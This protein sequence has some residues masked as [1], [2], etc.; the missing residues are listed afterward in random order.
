M[1]RSGVNLPLFGGMLVSLIIHIVFLPLVVFLLTGGGIAVLPTRPRVD[2][3]MIELEYPKLGREDRSVTT[4]A[5]I[6]YEDYRKLVAPLSFTEQPAV[7]DRQDPQPGSPI[8]IDPVQ[9]VENEPA[10][11]ESAASSKQ[12]DRP[13][14]SDWHRPWHLP[15]DLPGPAVILPPERQVTS[16]G[17]ASPSGEKPVDRPTSAPRDE[18][19]ADPVQMTDH[20]LAWRPGGVLVGEGIEVV[21]ARPEFGIITRL[22]AIPE[23]TE[24]ELVFDSD[25]M[26]NQARLLGSTGFGDVD[27][28]VLASLYKWRARGEKIENAD[29]FVVLRLSYG[30]E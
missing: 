14:S 17:P 19:A 27:A 30:F 26:V 6:D 9:R 5:W 22:T 25:G 3:P 7:Q 12:V 16:S 24:V 23:S 11:Q 21:T 13:V 8:Q 29:P 28:A 15:G 10:R 18:Q 1:Y 20:E 4:V 2:S